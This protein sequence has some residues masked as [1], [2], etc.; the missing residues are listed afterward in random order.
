MCRVPDVGGTS[1]S[2]SAGR[3]HTA[4]V[5]RV[6]SPNLSLAPV[7]PLMWSPWPRFSTLSWF[8]YQQKPLVSRYFSTFIWLFCLKIWSRSRCQQRCCGGNGTLS[9]RTWSRRP[10]THLLRLQLLLPEC[11]FSY[12]CTS[13]I[14]VA[15]LFPSPSPATSSQAA[16]EQHRPRLSGWWQTSLTIRILC[17]LRF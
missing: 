7:G 10:Q 8:P 4:D 1:V 2:R 16:T 17:D 6:S 14:H 3:K 13:S 5:P 12:V 15:T 9:N 11:P